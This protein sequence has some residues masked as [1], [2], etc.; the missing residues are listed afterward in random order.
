M[1]SSRAVRHERANAAARR[2]TPPTRRW[3]W[4]ADDNCLLLF[5]AIR[6]S[7]AVK[8]Q[9]SRN[10]PC[11]KGQALD[12]GWVGNCLYPNEVIDMKTRTASRL[13]SLK[14]VGMALL[15]AGLAACATPFKADVSR[16]EAQ[17]PAPQGETF[18]VVADDPA[19]EI[20][21]ASCRERVCQY[22]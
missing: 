19:L 14:M 1:R 6:H 4:C 12:G 13:T 5:A 18:A 9:A 22:V 21:R 8:D 20:G 2:S 10:L 3:G 15:V 11:F 16:F 17:L 7:I